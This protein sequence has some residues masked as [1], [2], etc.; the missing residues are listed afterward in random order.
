MQKPLIRPIVLIQAWAGVLY[1]STLHRSSS[2]NYRSLEGMT[3][4]EVPTALADDAT[5]E[6]VGRAVRESLDRAR[7]G[8]PGLKPREAQPQNDAML[9]RLGLRSLTEMAR[10]V[11]MIY[12]VRE[13]ERYITERRVAEPRLIRVELDAPTD[14]QLGATVLA[15]VRQ[16][17]P[18]VVYDALRR[19]SINSR[20]SD[21]ATADDEEN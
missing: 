5:P 21:C 19:R 10:K 9:R 2:G 3:P 11:A 13:G 8:V 17:Q 6:Q 4:G 1:I 14:V 7:I 16:H 12:V 18:A 15:E 20:Q